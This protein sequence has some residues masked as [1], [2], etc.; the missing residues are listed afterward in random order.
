MNT[1]HE[2]YETNGHDPLDRA[3]NQAQTFGPKIQINQSG[4][5]T[6]DTPT[7]SITHNTHTN[8]NTVATTTRN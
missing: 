6:D 2:K 8:T 7:Q 3:P 5:H 1:N 4:S